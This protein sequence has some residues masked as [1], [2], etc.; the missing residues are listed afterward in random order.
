MK[1]IKLDP[2]TTRDECPGQGIRQLRTLTLQR[3]RSVRDHNKAEEPC[4]IVESDVVVGLPNLGNT[5]YLNSVL[6]CLFCIPELICYFFNPHALT[7]NLTVHL[8]PTSI[9]VNRSNDDNE[10]SRGK[11]ILKSMGAG[12]EGTGGLLAKSFSTLIQKIARTPHMGSLNR[13]ENVSKWRRDN[14]LT[15]KLLL[16][17]LGHF[18]AVSFFLHD[19][20]FWLLKRCK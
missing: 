7:L 14:P 2:A 3:F 6:Q 13:V 5:C 15:R 19:F 10:A 1:K 20:M 12:R 17:P 16:G 18:K 4:K 8:Q 9:D 11:Q